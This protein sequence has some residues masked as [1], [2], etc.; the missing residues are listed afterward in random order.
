[1]LIFYFKFVKMLDAADA[2]KVNVKGWG[3]DTEPLWIYLKKNSNNCCISR[4]IW[5]NF[6]KVLVDKAGN[7]RLYVLRTS[8][9]AM[10]GILFT[11]QCGQA[12]R[13]SAR[14]SPRVHCLASSHSQ[15]F[16]PYTIARNDIAF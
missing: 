16:H 3:A 12:T 11:A 14:R 13:V 5:W 1:M 4:E 6:E 15:L 10:L 9:L 8:E 2:C 7:V